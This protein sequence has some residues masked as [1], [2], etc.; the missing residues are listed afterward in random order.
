MKKIFFIFVLVSCLTAGFA[1]TGYNGTE[2]DTNRN[3]IDFGEYA[4][5]WNEDNLEAV[6]F[7]AVVLG[8]QTV[9][10]YLFED[11]RLQGISYYLISEDTDELLERLK[12]KK[13]IYEVSADL[14][15]EPIIDKTVE[16][17]ELPEYAKED[18]TGKFAFKLIITEAILWDSCRQIET[19]G[20]KKIQN[21]EKAKGKIYIFDYNEDTRVYIITE[22]LSGIGF[23]VYVPHFQDF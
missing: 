3:L 19:L 6:S 18:D 9:E 17:A 12:T 16:A 5:S 7:T 23:V 4:E 11:Q 21:D 15:M 8:R 14:E 20:Y 2:W 1:E 22:V 10:S 13:K